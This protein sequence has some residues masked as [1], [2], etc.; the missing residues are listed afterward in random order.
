MP[1]VPRDRGHVALVLG[2]E[3]GAESVPFAEFAALVRNAGARI[4][5]PDS[6]LPVNRRDRIGQPRRTT[7]ERR[8]PIRDLAGPGNVERN[9]VGLP[10][11]EPIS[12]DARRTLAGP[13]LAV[14]EAEINTAYRLVDVQVRRFS[15]WIERRNTLAPRSVRR[16]GAAGT[17]IRRTPGP[18]AHEQ[19][20]RGGK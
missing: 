5:D 6:P 2:D 11:V 16:H 3:L 9:A 1:Y 14:R 10:G 17:P 8:S 18:S 13:Y 12:A 19:T 15:G 4:A 7:A 20:R